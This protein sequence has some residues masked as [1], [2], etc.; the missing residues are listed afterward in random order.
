MWSLCFTST[1]RESPLSALHTW[2][3]LAPINELTD[4][5]SNIAMLVE[6]N[7]QSELKIKKS[8]ET[9]MLSSQES[10]ILEVL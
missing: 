1:I 7:K 6:N 3:V 9:L 8:Y 10:Q 5:N 4:V 2:V